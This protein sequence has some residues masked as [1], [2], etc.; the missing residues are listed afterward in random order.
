MEQ[1]EFLILKNLIHNE[2]Y[3]RKSIPFIKSEYFEDPHQKMVYEEIFSFVEKYN[4]LPTK[5]VLS[6]EVEK[7]DDINEDSFKSVTHLI[8][9][10]DESPVENEWLIDT[11]EKWCRDRAIYLALLDS[12]AIADG[13]DDK[14][15]RDAIPS[16]LSDALAVSFDNHI[17]HDY[18]Q[19][20]EERYEFYHQKEEKIP[21]DLEFFN[22]ITKGGLPNKTLNIAL[23]GTGVGKS[24]FMCHVASSCLL[25]DKNVLYITME[26]A[27]EKIAER[28]D[29]NLLNVGIQDIVDLPKPMFSTKVNNITKKT[30]GSLVIKEYP[31]ASAHSGHFK[32]LLT[33][34]SLKKS[35]KPDI[36][37]VDYLNICASS[38]YRANA[39]VNSYSYIKAIA[40]EL[41]GLAV[42]TNVPI[43]S[44]TQ[45]T[46]S[47]YGSSDV[48]LTDTS[49]SFGLPATADLMFALIS[50]EEL[51]GLNQI[52]VK[53]LKNRYNDPTIYKRFVIGIDRAKMRL[54]DCE[55]SAQNDLIDTNQEEGYTKDD[56]FKPKSTFADFKF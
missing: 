3:L 6:I 30:M 54:Y 24:L 41:R 44:A 14:K 38:R 13:K 23:A 56:K 32:A 28:I 34:L 31:T 37:F 9:C 43:V 26:M 12:I 39:N 8:S 4:E 20:Y 48:E 15:G 49:E 16:I 46:R 25:Q 40:E 35:F 42:E 11:T 33:E 10:L 53:Q 19:D 50:T 5:E 2:K 55:Q 27:E 18:L 51:E 21:F 45:T 1:I 36:I 22:K 47:G 17:G 52:L 7:R 29:A